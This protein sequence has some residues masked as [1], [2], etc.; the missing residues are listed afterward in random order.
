MKILVISRGYMYPQDPVLGNFEAEQ[1]WTLQRMG[2][3]VAFMSV[4]RR[5]KVG[6]FRKIGITSFID[7]TGMPVYNCHVPIYCPVLKRNPLVPF[8][9]G[10]KVYQWAMM[11]LYRRVEKEFGRPDV[12]YS[13]YLFNSFMAI[14]LKKKL[15]IPMVCVEHW[16]HMNSDDLLPRVR[17]MGNS[18]Y[19]DVDK[20][21]SVSNATSRRLKQHFDIDSPVVFNMIDTASFSYVEEKHDSFRFVT[22]GK[23]TTRKGFDVLVKAFAKAQF[24]KDVELYII[25]SGDWNNIKSL[26]SQ[27]KM[28]SQIK[29][30]GP[31]VDRSDLV[32]VMHTCSAFVLPSRKETFSVVCVEA[33]SMGLPVIVTPCGGPEEYIN[34]NNGMLVPI[35]DIDSLAEAMKKL[36]A[37]YDSY[38]RK[39]ISDTTKKIYSPEFIGKQVES[40]LLEAVNHK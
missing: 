32:D 10:D 26:V 35:D 33:L 3:Q 27:L 4:D 18:V 15:G 30:V 8:F 1:A 23:N 36:I 5:I 16:S 38:D 12:I 9:I 31:I 6:H 28:E 13:H 22:L 24:S 25:G 29:V 7:K 20:V 19:Y 37:Q 21:I 40:Y 2:H 39:S 11:K 14:D 34:E 17:K